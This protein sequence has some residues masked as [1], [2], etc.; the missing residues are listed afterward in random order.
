[1]LVLEEVSAKFEACSR[2]YGTLLIHNQ[3]VRD[4]LNSAIDEEMDADANVFIIGEKV[5]RGRGRQWI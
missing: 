5:R 2:T 1:M 3:R 4:A